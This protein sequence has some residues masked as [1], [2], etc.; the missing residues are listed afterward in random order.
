MIKSLINKI[1]SKFG[2]AVITKENWRPKH[3]FEKLNIS[4]E[5]KKSIFENTMLNE[6]R[7]VNI[8]TTTDYL[9]NNNIRGVF[10]ECGVWK[11]G[12]VALMAYS[13]KKL[14]QLRDIHLFDCFD[15][16][17]E[18]NAEVDGEKAVREAG[19]ASF[20]KGN[21]TPVK[22]IYNNKGGSGNEIKVKSLLVENIG[23][24]SNHV[25]IHKGWFQDTIPNDES[26]NEIALLR[27]DGDW[28]ES[29]KV[30]LENLYDKV[31]PGGAIIV[32]DYGCYEGC[33]K[34]V[35]EFLEMENISPFLIKVDDECIY[36]IK[37]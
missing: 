33:K 1:L 25:I 5:I 8:V 21:L 19:G 36:W 20:A 9:V 7:L 3:D 28:Y 32:D 23:Y 30:C 2:Y 6:S 31:V 11:G 26:I 10:V 16:I 14:S 12:S 18:P 35:D 22:G 24:D 29:T 27:L 17:C 4:P 37:N 13:L 34:A 15:D